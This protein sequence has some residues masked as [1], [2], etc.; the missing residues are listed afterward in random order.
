MSK[1][2]IAKP[3]KSLCIANR[4]EIVHRIASTASRMGIDTTTVYTQPDAALPSATSAFRNLSLGEEATG[5]IDIERVVKTA[6]EAGCD[7]IHPGYGFLSENA[8]FARRVREEGLVFVG[9]PQEAIEAMG[10]KSRSKEIMIAANVPCVPGYH[11]TNQDPAFLAKEADKIGYPVLIKAVLGGGGKGMRIVNSAAEFPAQLQSAKSEARS[12]FGDENVLV[13]KYIRTPRHIEVQVFADRHGNVVAL[14]ERD[15]SVQRRHQ[16]VLEESPAPG[17]DPATRE[18]LWEKARLAAR[19]VGYEGAGTV[20]F[21]FDNDSGEFFFMEMN[22]RLQVEHPVTEAVTNTDLVEWQLLVAAGFPLPKTQ[23]EIDIEGHAFEARIYCEDAFKDFLPSS[24]EIVHMQYPTTGEPRLDLTFKQNSTVSS[25]YDPMIGKLIVKGRNR[26]EALRKL[27]QSL[28]EFEIVGPITNIEFIKR[29]IET[30]T[31]AGNE[32]TGLETGFIPKNKD[33]LIRPFEVNDKVYAQAALAHVAG[34]LKV[35][36]AF[37]R[38]S[39][40]NSAWSYSQVRTL[41]FQDPAGEAG[42]TVKAVAVQ[43]GPHS[44]KVS[45]DGRPGVEVRSVYFE[46]APG[47]AGDVATRKMHIQF[48]D[49]QFINTVVATTDAVHVFHDGVHYTLETPRP[50]WLQQALGVKETKNSVVAPMPCKIMRL[51]DNIS[52]GATVEKD[53]ELLVIESMKMETTIRAPKTGVIK[54]IAHEAGEIV[55][56]GTVLVEFKD[57]EE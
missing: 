30:D 57:E 1:A 23:E 19:A 8:Q 38:F 40:G 9:P 50:K 2:S 24:G 54:K 43:T 42:K 7:S 27:R 51:G 15:C 20:E 32:P 10:A 28:R 13:E 37:S 39:G 3:L 55:K 18:S 41:E 21:I 49:S 22:T 46:S 52:V 14:G 36:D 53:Q 48:N 29:I 33:H 11:G 17:L 44:Y 47:A 45:V 12:S 34:T 25:L 56:Q 4:G 6:K 35:P 16:K 26:D 31:F 5:Y